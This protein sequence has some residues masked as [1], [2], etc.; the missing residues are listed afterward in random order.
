[1][2]RLLGRRRRRRRGLAALAGEASAERATVGLAVLAIGAAG[3][4]VTGELLRLARRRRD[5]QE[6]DTPANLVDAAGYATRDTIAVARRG[7]RAT[8]HHE[9]LLFNILQG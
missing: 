1:M 3:T 2:T 8:A 4:L 6:T 5:S 7:I 9:A